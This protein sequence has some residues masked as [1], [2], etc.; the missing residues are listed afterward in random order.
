M[1][2]KHG[3]G[4]I[5]SIVLECLQHV[6]IHRISQLESIHEI[7]KLGRCDAMAAANELFRHLP[8]CYHPTGPN[9][10]GTLASELGLSN[11]YLHQSIL[12]VEPS[13]VRVRP[14]SEAVI[15]Y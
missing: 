4:N 13:G 11:T 9:C 1:D 12:T 8:S 15:E 3:G 2:R 5:Q 6:G 7:I 10:P 14:E